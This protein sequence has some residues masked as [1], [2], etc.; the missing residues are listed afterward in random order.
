MLM[1]IIVYAKGACD[2]I[3]C[4]REANKLNQL[5]GMNSAFVILYI[6]VQCVLGDTNV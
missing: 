1:M 2:A 5:V 4:A 3:R 6:I